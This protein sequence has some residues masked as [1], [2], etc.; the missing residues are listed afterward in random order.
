MH[1]KWGFIDFDNTMMATE[2]LAV[3]SLIKRFNEL[4]GEHL[5]SPLTPEIFQENFH[6]MARESLCKK[7]EVVFGIDVPYAELFADREWHIMK[8]Y[9]EQG[10]EMASGIIDAFDVLVN[11]GVV[12]SFVSN[13]PVQRGLAAMRYAT[14]GQGDKLASLMGTRFFEAGDK[15]KP[16]PDVYQRAIA[17]VKADVTKSFSVEDSVTGVKSA[18]AAGLDVYGYTGLSDNSKELSEKLMD[19]GAKATFNDWKAFPA[20][21]FG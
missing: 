19:S 17:Q 15:Q 18:V 6:G 1:K 8:L 5:Q 3:P 12:L 2:C 7:M 11:S 20:L 9:A 13:N 16:L 4:Y 21:L 14:N 10:V